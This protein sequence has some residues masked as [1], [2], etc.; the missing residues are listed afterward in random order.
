MDIWDIAI[1]HKLGDTS[2]DY[3]R[4]RAEV[5]Q[6]REI[7]E[8]KLRKLWKLNFSPKDI[9]QDKHWAIYPPN[10]PVKRRV[11]PQMTSERGKAL[12]VKKKQWIYARALYQAAESI[13]QFYRLDTATLAETRKELEGFKEL[14]KKFAHKS[15]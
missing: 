15:K 14:M 6:I 13:L 9:E 12:S 1:P 4:W 10:R 3:A 5:L 8:Y 7:S 2:A 11:A